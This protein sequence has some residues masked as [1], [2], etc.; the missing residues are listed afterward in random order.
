MKTDNKLLARRL[1]EQAIN[2][3]SMDCLSELISA[4]CLW[5]SGDVKG[6]EGF[7]HHAET[8]L[9]VYPDLQVSIDG[10][11][12]EDDIV[13]TWFTA[14]GTHKGGW[15]KVPPTHRGLTLKGVNVQRFRH[16]QIVEH[17]GGSNSLEA[18][19]EIGVV[20]WKNSGE[21]NFGSKE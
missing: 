6:P 11:V 3:R 21:T 12:A 19:L 20:Q 7:R 9:H 10:Q 16:G 13:V 2:Q 1:L 14:I 15:Q 4:D 18:L 8:M 5:Q 17:W